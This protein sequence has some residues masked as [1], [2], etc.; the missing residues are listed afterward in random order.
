MRTEILGIKKS[1]TLEGRRENS[2]GVK[3]W[4]SV[5]PMDFRPV[6]AV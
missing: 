1:H 6:G 5:S 2:P 4:E 3:P